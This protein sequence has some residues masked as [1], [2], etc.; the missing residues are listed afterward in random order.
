MLDTAQDALVEAL[1]LLEEAH[2]HRVRK[3]HVGR[4]WDDWE[5]RIV[6]PF[7]AKHRAEEKTEAVPVF[8]PR[9]K[10]IGGDG[11][12]HDCILELQAQVGYLTDAVRVLYRM[13]EGRHVT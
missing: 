11:G 2:D 10:P 5:E 1:R 7:L 13:E 6:M 4:D 9:V 8:T 3:M 12:E